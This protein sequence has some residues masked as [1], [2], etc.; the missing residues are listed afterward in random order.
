[1]RYF[2]Y[3]NF[4]KEST[5]VIIDESITVKFFPN[6]NGEGEFSLRKSDWIAF[7]AVRK[8]NKYDVFEICENQYKKFVE[9][10]IKPED[11]DW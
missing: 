9:K 11:W 10:G 1:V 3:T 2:F 5:I 7:Y 4:K 6:V 8:R